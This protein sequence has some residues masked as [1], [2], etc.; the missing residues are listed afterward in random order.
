MEKRVFINWLKDLGVY[1]Q[2]IRNVQSYRMRICYSSDIS[3]FF[4]SLKEI[5]PRQYVSRAF[6]WL[7]TPEGETFWT[8]IDNMWRV[9]VYDTIQKNQLKHQFIEWLKSHEALTIFIENFCNFHH[10]DWNQFDSKMFKYD[11]I[12]WIDRAFTWMNTSQ[13]HDYWENLDVEWRCIIYAMN[14]LPEI[15]IY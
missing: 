2:F 10:T 9:Y 5:S 7:S 12:S 11:P 8:R 15:S 3:P 4:E 14:K 1:D 6:V 13:R